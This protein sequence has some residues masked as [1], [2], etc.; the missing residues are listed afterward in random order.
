MIWGM[1]PVFRVSCVTAP[2]FRYACQTAFQTPTGMGRESSIYS[3][4]PS[5]KHC[6]LPPQAHHLE[7]GHA[8]T[9]A[10]RAPSMC[11]W[12]E[13]V[14]RRKAGVGA[15]PSV[16]WSFPTSDLTPKKSVHHAESSHSRAAINHLISLLLCEEENTVT[17]ESLW[18]VLW[19]S[20][21][22][23]QVVLCIYINF[24]Q[25]VQFVNICGGPLFVWWCNEHWRNSSRPRPKLIQ[26]RRNR[27]STLICVH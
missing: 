23:P 12:L 9:P 8:A 21:D 22:K 2:V 16:F 18:S 24:M 10:E 19:S 26:I 13:S 11:S 5:W 1:C 14:T 15:S 27:A 7:L 17:H 20:G 3:W 25:L 4:G 6:P